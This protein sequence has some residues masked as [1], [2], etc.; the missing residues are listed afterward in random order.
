M[1]KIELIFRDLQDNRILQKPLTTDTK[2]FM[3]ILSS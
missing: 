2:K 1:D 3:I